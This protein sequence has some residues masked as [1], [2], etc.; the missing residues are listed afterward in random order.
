MKQGTRKK[1]QLLSRSLEMREYVP[2]QVR[3]P[4]PYGSTFLEPGHTLASEATHLRT[5]LCHERRLIIYPVLGHLCYLWDYKFLQTGIGPPDFINATY[6]PKTYL[7]R[8]LI[9]QGRP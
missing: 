8:G 7:T 6:I 1:I 2:A 4:V 3:E 9:S 5:L